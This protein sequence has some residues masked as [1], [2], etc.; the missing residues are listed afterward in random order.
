MARGRPIKTE[1]REKIASILSQTGCAYGYEIYKLYKEMFE[2]VSLRNIYYNLKKGTSTGEFII[3]EAKRES[4]EYTWG[5]ES[6][7]IYYGLGPYASAFNMTEKQHQKISNLQ[8]KPVQIDWLKETQ[9]KIKELD[10]EIA[11]FHA[12]KAHMK[13]EDVRKLNEL[14]KLHAVKLKEWSTTKLDK[15]KHKEIFVQINDVLK[16]LV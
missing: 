5:T 8:Q 10:N 1:I 16:N 2:P 7:H 14:L 3:L 4:G 11:T 9:N 12:K 6:E 15:E 13:Y